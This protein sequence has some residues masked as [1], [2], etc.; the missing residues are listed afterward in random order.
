MA[1]HIEQ[2]PLPWLGCLGARKALLDKVCAF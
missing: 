2:L 1:A